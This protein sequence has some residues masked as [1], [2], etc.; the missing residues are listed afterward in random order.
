MDLPL[1]DVVETVSSVSDPVDKRALVSLPELR[2]PTPHLSPTL[3]TNESV[4]QEPK[5]DSVEEEQDL[6][7]VELA[8]HLNTLLVQDKRFFGSAR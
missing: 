6:S 7:R 8:E 3:S 4:V 5:V 2:Y 1:S